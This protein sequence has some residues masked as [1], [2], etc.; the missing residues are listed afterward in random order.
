MKKQEEA[1]E[2]V[3]PPEAMRRAR[4][5][6]TEHAECFWMRQPGAPVRDCADVELIIRR[7]REN[8][9]AAAWQTAWEIE[10]C[11]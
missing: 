8:G 7:L 5:A 10:A 3:V 4:R 2:P 1:I 6:L 9:R 11:L